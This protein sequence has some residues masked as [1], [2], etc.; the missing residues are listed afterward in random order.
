MDVSSLYPNIDH[1]EGI[2]ACEEMLPDRK[3]P[4][5]PTSVISNLLKLIFK[6]NTLKFGTRLFHQIKGTAMGTPLA[7]NYATY[8]WGD[9][10][11]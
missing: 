3:S 1:A 2:S 7:C 10:S 8:S 9:L 5:V 11:D 4:S 6:C